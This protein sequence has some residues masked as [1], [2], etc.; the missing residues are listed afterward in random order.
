ML[1]TIRGDGLPRNPH[2]HACGFP[3]GLR[4][5]PSKERLFGTISVEGQRT[6][7]MQRSVRFHIKGRL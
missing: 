6:N 2:S 3:L 4:L 7:G 5:L 1:C